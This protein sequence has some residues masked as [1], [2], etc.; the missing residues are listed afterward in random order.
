MNIF[1]IRII[2][3]SDYLDSKLLNC[4]ILR[5]ILYVLSKFSLR[6]AFGPVL[7]QWTIWKLF[8]VLKEEE[9][10]TKGEHFYSSKKTLKD[11]LI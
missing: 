9:I 11:R 3:V 4:H 5:F 10:N 2:D 7:D 1:A 6:P 8:L